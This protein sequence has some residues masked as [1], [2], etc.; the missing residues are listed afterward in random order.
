MVYDKRRQECIPKHRYIAEQKLGRRLK[1]D[2]YVHHVDHNKHHNAPSNLRVIHQSDHNKIRHKTE[3]N[4]YGRNNP[5]KHITPAR[6]AEMRRAWLRRKRMFG[7]TGARNPGRLR[8]L[9]RIN[10][11][12][13]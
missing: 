7:N 12:N 8:Q 9:G 2:E 11:Q 10:G 3:R 6:R 4:F 5:S 1:S 13:K